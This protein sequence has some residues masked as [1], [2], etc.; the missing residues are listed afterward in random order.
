MKNKLI[1]IIK[2]INEVKP[3]LDKV[4]DPVLLYLS[5]NVGLF[6]AVHE[7]T[8]NLD[9]PNQLE[10]MVAMAGGIVAYKV[11]KT[12]LP[13][14]KNKLD[15]SNQTLIK[16]SSKSRLS[17]WFKTLTLS[18]ALS[19]PLYG[20]IKDNDPITKRVKIGYVS[21]KEIGKKVYFNKRQLKGRPEIYDQLDYE[22]IHNPIKKIDIKYLPPPL[23]KLGK[24]MRSLRWEPI[25]K[26]VEDKYDIP[27]GT[28]LAIISKESLGNPLQPNSSGDG[29]LGL[30]HFQP[31]TAKEYGL[32]IYGKTNGKFTDNINGESINELIKSCSENWQC[33]AEKDERAHPIKNIDA[34]ARKVAH[35]GIIDPGR[36]RGGNPHTRKRY[37][38]DIKKLRQYINSKKMLLEARNNFS[39]HQQITFDEWIDDH[40]KSNYNWGL[41]KYKTNFLIN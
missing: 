34:M 33:V 2:K 7:G 25:T 11:N 27:K 13:K 14:I 3:S 29:G 32:K 19:A 4:V 16:D 17:S 39:K 40:H 35:N 24:T 1:D 38:N 31:P 18:L 37:K 36:F 6:Y 20:I 12:V 10:T 5:T 26:V 30:G 9:V 22:E 28:L 8:S 41:K 21:K 23:T 15:E